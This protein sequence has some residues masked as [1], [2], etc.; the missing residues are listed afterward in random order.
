M[1]VRFS[2][3]RGIRFMRG[4][5]DEIIGALK[6]M[7][8]T[9]EH[10]NNNQVADISGVAPSTIANWFD[11]DT[12]KPQNATVMALTST[13][14][15][16]RRDYRNRDGTVSPGFVKDQP[17]IDYEAEKKKQADWLLKQG[18]P[19]KKRTKKKKNGSPQRG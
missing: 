15:Y 10:L 8:R 14:G 2:G 18:R 4:E 12:K 13:L 5:K 19:K 17:D 6:T 1:K 7:I 9:D 11:G 16:L 3:Y